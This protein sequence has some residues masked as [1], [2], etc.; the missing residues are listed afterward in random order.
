MLHEHRFGRIARGWTKVAGVSAA[1]IVAAL[2]V[3]V[4]T[5]RADDSF[6][7]VDVGA[8]DAAVSSQV[9]TAMAVSSTAIA[10][11]ESVTPA[12][13][14]ARVNVDMNAL[15]AA[16]GA[17]TEAE[18]G[19][20]ARQAP[21]ADRVV[22]AAT[23]TRAHPPKSRPRAW[24]QVRG[25]P[26]F[27][28]GRRPSAAQLPVQSRPDAAVD[29]RTT[30]THRQHERVVLP[31][32]RAPLSPNAPSRNDPVISSGGQ[33]NG[34]GTSAPAFAAAL[35]AL[36]TLAFPFLLRRVIWLAQPVPRRSVHAPWRPG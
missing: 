6:A 34:L 1:A 26:P 21:P 35:A 3:G 31:E 30:A 13:T 11:A 12:P 14:A 10:E 20:D 5:A 25:R 32:Q 23:L 27:R 8:I 22:R 16:A 29:P 15:P 17:V 4:G 18:T 9:E 33:G 2:G 19:G 24:P 7:A 36:L 28:A